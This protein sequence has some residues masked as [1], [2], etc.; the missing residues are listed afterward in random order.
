VNVAVKLPAP[1]V[2]EP[3]TVSAVALLDSVTVAPP[4]FDRVT[5]HVAFAPDPRLVGL[6]VSPLTTVAVASEIAAV[7][8]LPFSFAVMVAVWSLVI[9]PAVAANVAVAL[10]APTVT[11]AGIAKTD[12]SFDSVTTAPA[13][14]DIVTVHVAL[15]PEPRLV[16]LQ[17]SPLTNTGEA[18]EIEVVCVLPFSVPVTVAV[19]SVVIV[20]AVAANVAV[21]LP[22]PT[23]TEAGTVSAPALLDSVTVAPLVFDTVTVH[24]ELAPE[25]KLV[26]LHVRP[27]TTVAVASAMVAVAVPPLSVAVTVA[28]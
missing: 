15:A 18:S 5:V 2:T 21:V 19:W 17:V 12:A 6:H 1:T 28:V 7:C 16:G 23:A 22:A 26:G 3:G 27:L 8:V 14:L 10:P 4:V 13:V 24:V 20:P 9:V 11:E 25:P